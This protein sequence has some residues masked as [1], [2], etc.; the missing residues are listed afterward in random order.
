MQSN[1]LSSHYWFLKVLHLPTHTPM[2]LQI[3]FCPVREP[4]FVERFLG[5]GR[6]FREI[7][8]FNSKRY[9]PANPRDLSDPFGVMSYSFVKEQ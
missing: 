3:I 8:L 1:Y 2:I 7:H 5:M 6:E 4:L 9:N